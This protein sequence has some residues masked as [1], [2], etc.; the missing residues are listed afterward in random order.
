MIYRVL[1]ENNKTRNMIKHDD[2][3]NIQDA[4]KAIK[5]LNSRNKK[6]K[7]KIIEIPENLGVGYD[8]YRA[9]G[10][11]YGTII[12]ETK[13]FYIVSPAWRETDNNLERPFFRK[14]SLLDK[15]AE[16]IF[17]PI[18]GDPKKIKK[19]EGIVEEDDYD[20]LFEE[21]ED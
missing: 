7:T 13:T 10:E 12:D 1:K 9:N 15:F 2:Y 17:K 6:R 19:Y 5:N 16:G 8:I 4:E 3:N 20:D 11:L 14:E 18:D 21:E